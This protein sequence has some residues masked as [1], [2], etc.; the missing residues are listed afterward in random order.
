MA[1]ASTAVSSSGSLV[2]TATPTA[3]SRDRW[4]DRGR[5]ARRLRSWSTDAPNLENR[6]LG[7]G[8]DLED[9]PVG[10]RQRTRSAQEVVDPVVV[11][12]RVV[13]VEHEPTHTGCSGQ[14]DGVLH[15]A[16]TPADLGRVAGGVI[17]RVV[18]HHVGIGEEVRVA[19]VGS[20]QPRQSAAGESRVVGL[21]VGGVHD[22]GAV[23]LDAETERERGVVQVLG[24]DGRV[25]DL[26]H[27]FDQVVVVHLRV[28][29]VQADREVLVLHLS[30]KHVVEGPHQS[31]G[32]NT[33]HRLPGTKSGA[34]NGRPWM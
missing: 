23:G 28:H 2:A 29:L 34:K 26:E 24:A 12:L 7:G 25:T 15:C 31:R 8:I 5:P 6:S 19:G 22:G 27:P 16:V 30:G 4:Y 17:L 14:R 21:V 33:S 1:A 10:G 3:R 13:V 11:T 9:S 20:A 32:P 18:H